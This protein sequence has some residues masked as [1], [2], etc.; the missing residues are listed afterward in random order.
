MP[1]FGQIQKLSTGDRDRRRHSGHPVHARLIGI[2]S[3]ASDSGCGL[4]EICSGRAAV[5]DSR[6]AVAPGSGSKDLGIGSGNIHIDGNVRGGCAG[7]VVGL[8][9]ETVLLADELRV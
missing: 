6:L 1:V 4:D 5:M 8:D 9:G 2:G 3:E 7:L